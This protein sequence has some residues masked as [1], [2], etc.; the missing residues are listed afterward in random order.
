MIRMK[1]ELKY[2][3]LEK[4]VEN[5]YREWFKKAIPDSRITSPYG[6]DGLLFSDK[7]NLWLLMEIKYDLD[8]KKS[9][10]IGRV[11]IQLLFYLKK[12]E[13]DGKEIPTILFVGDVN[14]CFVL[15]SN[16]I[17]KFLD[18]DVD[19]DTAPS[20][21]WEKYPDLKL[22]LAKSVNPFVYSIDDN[23]LF[24]DVVESVLKMNEG[25][26]RLIRIT[27]HNVDT[28]FKYFQ[29]RVLKGQEKNAVG[30]FL[31]VLV[32]RA[33]NFLHPEKTST[34]IT[35]D[36]GNVS[37]DGKKF[38]AFFQHFNK[39]L[40]PSEKEQLVAIC[41]RLLQDEKRRREG[42]FFT[43]TPWV[44]K[45]HEMT[46]EVLGE[47]WRDEYVVWDCAAGT[48]NLTRDYRF[49]ELYSS[50]LLADDINIMKQ[51]RINEGAERFVYDF[52][53]EEVL[54]EGIKRA[55]EEKKKVC[56]FINPPYGTANNMGTKEGDHKA[57]I[58]KTKMNEVMKADKIGACSQQL[59]A[60][61]LYR[62]LQLQKEYG[63]EVVI[64]LFAPPLY[65]T[66]GS[67]KKFRNVFYNGFK[68]LDGFLFKASHFADVAASWGISFTLWKGGKE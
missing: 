18:S 27:Q 6:C 15:H 42:A 32:N 48:G 34:L 60:Q 54:P 51:S 39:D 57:G 50:T 37:V 28:V 23:S 24:E 65:M 62:I 22:E 41:D 35:K 12:F 9:S 66:G 45:A 58:A 14:E 1:Q 13:R 68:F 56:F 38:E 52:L 17:L 11:L 25:V 44:D 64:C 7:N 63:N 3:G 26:V 5:L 40:K 31:S 59:Y 4:D 21:A 43:P 10:E 67:Y 53:N 29:D 20:S 33:E 19:W 49:K 30:I 47:N 2:A 61:F 55:F 36:Y 46:T 16:G 8:F